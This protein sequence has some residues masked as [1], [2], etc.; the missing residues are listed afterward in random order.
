MLYK[1]LSTLFPGVFTVRS[2]SKIQNVEWG[3]GS[4][5]KG[6]RSKKRSR[7]HAKNPLTKS[8]RKSR[9]G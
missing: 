2:A 8:Q 4:P 5:I 7:K 1:L 6:A 9:R 3:K